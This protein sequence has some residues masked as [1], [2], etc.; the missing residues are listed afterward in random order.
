MALYV[1]GDIQ[2]K[3]IVADVLNTRPNDIYAAGRTADQK[4]KEETVRKVQVAVCR[5]MGTTMRRDMLPVLAGPIQNSD[6]TVA[7]AACRAAMQIG[8]QDFGKRLR[9]A[10]SGF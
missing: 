1:A 4:F 10:L 8:N 6:P 5:L 2:A 9:K 7:L 3:G